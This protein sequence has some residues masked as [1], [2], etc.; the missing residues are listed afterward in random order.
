MRSRMSVPVGAFFSKSR[1]MTASSASRLGITEK[2]SSGR[3][4]D[5]NISRPWRS[6]T[7]GFIGLLFPSGGPG[8]GFEFD[9]ARAV[10]VD[11]PRVAEPVDERAGIRVRVTVQQK[12]RAV[13]EN[14]LAQ[15]G[16]ADVR[17]VVRVVVDAE[18]RAVAD[19]DVGGR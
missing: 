3:K 11:D 14:P 10:D 4:F 5:G 17:G 18:R 15:P 1:A 13:L 8:S 9:D 12:P 7:K 16:E 6:M 19:D 2:S